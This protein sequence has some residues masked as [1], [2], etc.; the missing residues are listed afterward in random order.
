MQCRPYVSLIALGRPDSLSPNLLEDPCHLRRSD[1]PELTR[2]IRAIEHDRQI[3]GVARQE[4][5]AAK[6]LWP[7]P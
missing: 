1:S 3:I 4:G 5:D 2:S 7:L 6:R